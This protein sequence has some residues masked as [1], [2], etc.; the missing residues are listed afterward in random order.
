MKRT[1]LIINAASGSAGA[2][3]EEEIVAGLSRAGFQVIKTIRLPDEE[4]PDQAEV[5]RLSASVIAILSGDGTI[6]SVC[7]EMAGWDGD[8]LVFPGGTMNLLSRRLH[9][10]HTVAELLDILGEAFAKGE[11]ITVIKTPEGDVYTGLIAGPSTQWGEVRES[12]R[13]FDIGELVEK[14]PEA[15]AA[16]T[17]N[18]S[19]RIE[20]RDG[21]YPAIFVEPLENGHLGVRAFRADGVGDMLSHG[22]A[23]LRRD[24]REGPNDDLGEM[25]AVTILDDVDQELGLLIDGE[26]SE[27]NSPL[28]CTAGM[29]SVRF[30]RTAQ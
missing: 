24:F 18:E 5:V 7:Q 26:Q 6:A 30:L 8:I 15:W 14:V 1:L 23:W 4:L 20:G 16:T 11:N 28:I 22:I 10:E 13:N 3:S 25:R 21:G 9:G 17:T 19:V 27:G 2:V 12:I 29:S